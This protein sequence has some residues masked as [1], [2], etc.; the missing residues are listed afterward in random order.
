MS[1]PIMKCNAPP[2][3]DFKKAYNSVRR[4]VF[5]NIIFGFDIPIKDIGVNKYVLKYTLQ[6]PEVAKIVS[7]FP[8]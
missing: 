3:T 2:F 8:Y 1:K 4:Q 6:K 7:S 5:Y